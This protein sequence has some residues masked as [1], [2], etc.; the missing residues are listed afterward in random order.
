[1]AD[2]AMNE[3]RSTEKSGEQLQSA[4]D[5]VKSNDDV[6]NLANQT[7]RDMNSMDGKAFRDMVGQAMMKEGFGGYNN[8]GMDIAELRLDKEGNIKELSF[9]NPFSKD[10]DH[11]RVTLKKGDN[12]AVNTKLSDKCLWAVSPSGGGGTNDLGAPVAAGFEDM[13]KTI[14]QKLNKKC[15]DLQEGMWDRNR[16]YNTESHKNWK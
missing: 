3:T 11:D 5:S 9:T 16:V 10:K 14:T 6:N 13:L 15:A 8:K 12:A 1:M 7:L 4:M 2:T